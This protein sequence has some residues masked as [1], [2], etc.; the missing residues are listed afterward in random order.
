MSSHR[1][2]TA[3][4]TPARPE[5]PGPIAMIVLAAGLGIAGAMACGLAGALWAALRLAGD[6][7]A[8]Q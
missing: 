2:D 4:K 7:D 8:A 6:S 5:T 1:S 3:E